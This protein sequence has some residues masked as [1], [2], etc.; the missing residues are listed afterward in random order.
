M[1][2]FYFLSLVLLVFQT[3]IAAQL[4]GLPGDSQNRSAQQIPSTFPVVNFNNQTQLLSSGAFSSVLIVGVADMNG[5]KLDDIIRLEDGK[6]LTIEYQTCGSN[7]Y[8]YT[9]GEVSQ[10]QQWSMA[11]ADVDGNGFNDIMVGGLN[12]EV[13]LLL[14]SSMGL[15]YTESVL[16]ESSFFVQGSNFVDI[17]EDG[18]VDAFICNDLGESKIWENTGS[19]NFVPADDWIDMATVPASNNAGNYASAW[20]DF[21]N[22]GDLDVYISKCRANVDDSTDPERINQLFVNDGNNSFSEMAETFGL[23]NGAQTW[24]SDFQDIDNDGDLDCFVVNHTKPDID[25]V[26]SQLFINDGFGNYTD[27]TEASGLD[28]PDNHLQ[29]ILRDF[30]NDGFVDILVAGNE[31]YQFFQNNGNLTFTE[32]TDIF[33]TYAMGTFAIGDLNHDGFLD[34]YSGSPVSNDVLW[35]N[36]KNDNNFIAINLEATSGEPNAIGARVEIYG[37]WGVQ[38]R[39][40]R[41]GESYGIMNSYTQYFGLGLYDEIDSLIIRW[42][43]GNVEEFQNPQINQFLNIVENECAYPDIHISCEG[44]VTL[45]TGDTLLLSAP[46]GNTYLWSNGEETSELSITSGGIYQVTVTNDYGCTSVS[47]PVEIIQDPIEIPTITPSGA[48]TFCAGQN[49]FL[50]GSAAHNYL[51]SNGAETQSILVL[52]SGEYTLTTSGVCQDFT[53]EPVVVQVIPI[54]QN[55]VVEDDVVLEENLPDSGTLTATGDNISWFDSLIDGDLLATGNTFLTPAVTETTSF[56]AQDITTIDNVTCSSQRVEAMV[57]VDSVDAT[58]IAPLQGELFSVYPNPAGDFIIFKKE[59]EN[60]EDILIKLVNTKGQLIF[61]EKVSPVNIEKYIS[62]NKFIEGM[63]VLMVER[64]DK[65]YFKKLVIS[66]E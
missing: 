36:S 1:A 37:S 11:I 18:L 20:T 47:V 19:G 40:V 16:P 41:A 43:S 63:Y 55:P 65:V 34:V 39:E 53:S 9:F 33:G 48:T 50:F 56:Y 28:I 46:A 52:Q 35:M 29:G 23:K 44:V 60:Y 58:T 30:D 49:V 32:V 13:K 51:W 66:R 54:P 31:G 38:I 45:C 12:D 62:T 5:D 2:K 15:F 61:E 22:D 17:N 4:Q 10:N 7:F 64:G 6:D 3:T 42:P 24:T 14:A 21:D 27:I 57:I 26:Q 8:S 25:T 59:K